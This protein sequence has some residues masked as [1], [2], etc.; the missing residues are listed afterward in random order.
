MFDLL[1]SWSRYAEV[2]SKSSSFDRVWYDPYNTPGKKVHLEPQVQCRH[3]LVCI[4]SI[5]SSPWYAFENIVRVL[6]NNCDPSKSPFPLTNYKCWRFTTPA[7]VRLSV[8]KSANIASF[9]TLL[10]VV[11]QCSSSIVSLMWQFSCRIL[12]SLSLLSALPR[13]HLGSSIR[14]PA[15]LG[16]LSPAMVASHTGLLAQHVRSSC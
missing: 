5:R 9:I 16:H 12:V 3:C 7:E 8:L 14:L 2:T 13:S 4:D 10:L 11:K 1:F 6:R 15:N